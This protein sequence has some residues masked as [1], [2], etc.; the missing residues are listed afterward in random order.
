VRRPRPKELRY[1][2]GVACFSRDA[3]IDGALFT[4]GLLKQT[5]WLWRP[6]LAATNINQEPGRC[7]R[8]RLTGSWL[9]AYIAF[10]HADT[11][12]VKRWY[13]NGD[14]ASRELWRECGFEQRPSYKTVW[15]RFGE[16]ENLEPII[17][18]AIAKLIAHARRHDP[19][20]GRIL[21]FDATE[22]D[23]H[24]QLIHDCQRREH[25]RRRARRR[26]TGVKRV[27]PK[28]A[29]DLRQQ[30]TAET[31][32]PDH[33]GDGRARIKLA[34]C[35][36]RTRDP[37]IGIR[38]YDSKDG[39]RTRVWIG[40]Y[41]LKAICH[42]TGL[43]TSERVRPANENEADIYLATHHHVT[44][45][46]KL[47]VQIEVFD[48]GFSINKVYET[49]A[50]GGRAA[51]MALRDQQRRARDVDQ[52]RY[53]RDGVP[54]CASCGG[55]CAVVRT[56]HNPPRIWFRCIA[57]AT[58]DCLS[59]SRRHE[60]ARA[61][62]QSLTCAHDFQRLTLLPRTDRAYLE[63]LASHSYYEHAHA[64][65]REHW[66]VAGKDLTSRPRR[67]GLGVCQLRAT[68][69]ILIDWLLGCMRCGY[70]GSARHPDISEESFHDQAIRAVANEQARRQR[71]GLDLPYGHQAAALGLGP[72][73]PPSRRQRAGPA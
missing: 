15:A 54:R 5:A 1:L 55:Q 26:G 4:I 30:E 22:A 60:P 7:C 38:A 72:A 3:R 13:K 62:Q 36:W 24:A 66:L 35:W 67:R 2:K 17:E 18:A 8:P 68:T 43:R 23:A 29:A 44:D 64:D 59:P 73:Q 12:H 71:E 10:L 39:R 31:T 14:G 32:R 9:L 27:D 28:D 21:H 47:P 33:L 45:N 50:R 52:P 11:V 37:E 58:P 57:P 65:A 6:L 46:L 69:S 19:L 40:R 61:R 49:N 34:G 63:L 25:C 42:R 51:V 48:K 41:N 70:L 56:D 16:L 53:D 20:I